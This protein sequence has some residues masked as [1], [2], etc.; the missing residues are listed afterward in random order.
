MAEDL[1]EGIHLVVIGAGL[2]GL[3]AAISTKLANP[4]HKVTVLETVKE[5]QEIGAGLQ[6]TP[7]GTRLLKRW[8]LFD[9]L[10]SQAS[11]PVTLS[12]HRYDGTKLLAHEPDLQKQMQ[13][14]YQAPFWDIHRVDLQRSMVAKCKALGVG[15]QLD[16]RAV[17][18]DF[19]SSEVTL[20]DGRKVQ[21]DVVLLSDGLWSSIRHQFVGQYC[22]AI[23]TGDLAYRIVIDVDD[24]TGPD[25][26]ELEAF[27][28]NPTVDFWVGPLSHSVGYS[29]RGGKTYNLVFLCPDDLPEGVAKQP[30]D[31][32]E[33]RALFSTWDPLLRK[34]LAQVRQVSKWKLM[35]LDALDRWANDPGTFFMAGDC[36]HPMLPYLAQG[37]NSSLEDGAVLGY[38]LGK[39]TR[40]ERKR[41]LRRAAEIY[42]RLRMERGRK[43]QLETFK[44]RDDFHMADG[45]AQEARDAKMTALLGKEITE[46]FPSRWTCPVIQPFLW[47]Y[48]AYAEVE[49]AFNENPY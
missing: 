22:P 2:A 42:Q 43:I 9:E 34:F 21:G 8:G 40:S 17:N 11:S 14:R 26:E 6:V 15:I 46:A 13:E 44:Q 45:E 38:L 19:A 29:M 33:M 41:Q 7:N 36:C 20:H 25:K 39:V 5:L 35:W 4:V 27:V 12:V 24:M 3:S 18:V 30:G 28:S 16:A 10:S 23:L 48:D 31:L 47:G 32:A 49:T 1:G 37:A